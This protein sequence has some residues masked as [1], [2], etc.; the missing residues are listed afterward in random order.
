M[1]TSIIAT[2]TIIFSMGVITIHHHHLHHQHH[3]HCHQ[4][5]EVIWISLFCPEVSSSTS[6][7]PAASLPLSSSQLSPTEWGS[8]DISIR[9]P[10][11]VLSSPFHYPTMTLATLHYFTFHY[12]IIALLHDCIT[13][14][15]HYYITAL[16]HYYITIHSIILQWHLPHY[17]TIDTLADITS[18]QCISHSVI[19]SNILFNNDWELHIKCK[20]FIRMF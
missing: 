3:Q 4:V 1:S 12:Y 10:E 6:S 19:V 8:L 7:S 20:S 13:T 16:L 17:I 2:T 5:N 11:S 9:P 14:L 15:L 18:M